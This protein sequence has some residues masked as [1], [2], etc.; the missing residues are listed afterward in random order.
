MICNKIYRV[1]INNVYIYIYIYM[2]A[3][4]MSYIYIYETVPPRTFAS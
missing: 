2:Y 3:L 4:D 1:I